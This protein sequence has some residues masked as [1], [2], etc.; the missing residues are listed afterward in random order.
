MLHTCQLILVGRL[1]EKS[2]IKLS[3]RL[4]C[5]SYTVQKYNDDEPTAIASQKASQEHANDCQYFYRK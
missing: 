1:I 5:S 3:L 4:H 2:V